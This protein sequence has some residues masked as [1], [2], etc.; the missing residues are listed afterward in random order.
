M[1]EP[2]GALETKR[3]GPPDET[4][5]GNM[6]AEH[7]LRPPQIGRFRTDLE[8]RVEH[9]LVKAFSRTQHHPVLAEGHRLLI[10]IGSNMPD[11]ENRHCNP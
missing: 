2:N 3:L 5:D 4:R 8:L 7:I 9:P 1:I 10:L 6:V 11:G